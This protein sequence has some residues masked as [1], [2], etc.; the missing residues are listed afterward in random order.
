M[1]GLYPRSTRVRER[2]LLLMRLLFGLK[3]VVAMH[4]KDPE[5]W[6]NTFEVNIRGA[7]NFFR[8]AS[9]LLSYPVRG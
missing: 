5:V 2:T 3:G 1:R 9:R 6:W 8:C 4:Q 7:F